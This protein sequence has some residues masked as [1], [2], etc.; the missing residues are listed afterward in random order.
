MAAVNC[1]ELTNVVMVAVPPKSTTEAATKFVPLITE[2]YT[3]L[4]DFPPEEHF[5]RSKAMARI[6]L[7]M[8]EGLSEAHNA[9]ANSLFLYD[10]DWAGAEKEFQRAI[11]LNPNYAM[12][13]QWYG[14]LLHALGRQNWAAEVQRAHELDPLSLTIAGGGWYL[15]KGQYDLA[16][17][18]MRKKLE[19]DPNFAFGYV[20]LG[21]VYARKGM[22][23]EAIV[24]I[25]KGLSL[26][27]SPGYLSALGYTYGL[28]GKRDEALK[29]LQQLKLLS[30]RRYVSPYGIAVVYVGLGEKDLAFDWLQKAVADRSTQLVSMKRDPRMDSMRSDPRYAE[31]E[32]RIGLPQ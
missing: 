8:D 25:K 26:D 28:S 27:E 21:G 31:L 19:L 20:W 10:W 4:L 29:I 17:E 7:Q 13:H 5:S 23:Q 18:N 1:V 3:T 16:I 11:A 22:Y 14:Q 32:R 30:K 2:A 6:A 12:A 15:E 9:L 24:Q